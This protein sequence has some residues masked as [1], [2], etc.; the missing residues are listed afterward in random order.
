[1]AAIQREQGWE[2]MQGAWTHSLVQQ[3]ARLFVG[4]SWFLD[5]TEL[6]LR[7]RVRSEPFL[8]SHHVSPSSL[9]PACLC[10]GRRHGSQGSRLHLSR[11]PPA[12]HMA[13]S[14]GLSPAGGLMRRPDQ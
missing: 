13:Q 3:A 2:V 12:A 7:V 4:L 10:S 8:L 9:L 11:P 6:C 5:G 1:M 14:P